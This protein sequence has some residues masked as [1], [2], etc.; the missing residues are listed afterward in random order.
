MDSVLGYPLYYGI[1]NGFGTPAANISAFV[2]VA[3]QVLTSFPVCPLR[4]CLSEMLMKPLQDPS[5]LG[6]FIE[7]HDLPRWRNATVD[8][9]LGY[10]A[11]VAQFIFDGIPIVY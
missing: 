10:N 2:S 11:M 5:L 1:V 8:P 7:N 6:N 4:F 9:Q 3:N